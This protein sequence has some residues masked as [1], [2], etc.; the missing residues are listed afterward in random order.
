MPYALE[1]I[2]LQCLKNQ[3]IDGDEIVMHFNGKVMFHWEDTGH[4]WA[5]EL[6][7]DEWT[8]FY[9][10]RNNR[11]RTKGG[12]IS[13]P[14]YADYGFFFT[15]L[16]GETV[17]DL[18]ESDEGNLLR[19]GDDH[20][21]RLVVSEAQIADHAYTVDFTAEDAHYRLTFAVTA[22]P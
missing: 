2:S 6:K 19:G 15:P 1:I 20:L 17:I 13:V 9:D 12:E 4:R 8:D 10:F 11:M 3:E 16:E 14:A 18:V 5:A 7:L 22:A 21:G